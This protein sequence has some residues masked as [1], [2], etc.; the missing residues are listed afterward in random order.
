[1][2]QFKS[3]R[4]QFYLLF[5]LSPLLCL[6]NSFRFRD[7]GIYKNILWFFIAFYGFTISFPKGDEN[8][9]GYRRFKNFEIISSRSE[10][11]FSE[12]QNEFSD[13]DNNKADVFEPL[14]VFTVSRVTSNPHIMFAVYGLLFGFFYSRNLSYI[15]DKI[16]SSNTKKVLLLLLLLAFLNPF[17]NI[18]GFRYWFATQIF[19]YGLL[20]YFFENKKDYLLWLGLTPFVHFSYLFPILVFLI[21]R[22]VG[23]RTIIYFVYFSVCFFLGKIDIPFFTSLLSFIPSKAIQQKAS[24]YTNESYVEKVVGFDNASLNWYAVFSSRFLYWFILITIVFCFLKYRKLILE[25]F[26][27]IFSF[28]LFYMGTTLLLVSVPSMSRFLVLGNLLVVSFLILLVNQNKKPQPMDSYLFWTKWGIIVFLV[29]N[30]RIAFDTVSFLTLFTN[31]VTAP[32]F[33]EGNFSII[34]IFK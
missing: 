3:K 27:P 22:I 33:M 1:M 14:L 20:R 15:L 5:L 4:E 2:S 9:D 24:V 28:I 17:W 29:V 34:N 13:E 11:S 12:F 26:K 10:F 19:L 21:Y 8:L 32:F 18:G 31:P 25:Q 23:D 30:L 7:N 6:I 16:S